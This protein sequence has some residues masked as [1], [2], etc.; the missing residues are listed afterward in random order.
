[1]QALASGGERAKRAWS[2]LNRTIASI[3]IGD[4]KR[5]KAV[6]LLQAPPQMAVVKK[7]T[8]ICHGE[9]CG[10]GCEK[11]LRPPPTK[12]QEEEEHRMVAALGP[13]S[14]SFARAGMQPS[15]NP[16]APARDAEVEMAQLRAQFPSLQEIRLQKA[17]AESKSLDEAI[18]AL[19]E[20]MLPGKVSIWPSFSSPTLPL[21][22]F[23][24]L[25]LTSLTLSLSHLSSA[26]PPA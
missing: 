22:A 3:P 12:Q 23:P 25:L 20:S 13:K 19:N 17:L 6:S 16:A 9:G 11:K 14:T 4:K 5:A 8:C 21:L 15:P 26:H 10:T 24:R 18:D 1:M 2:A 7:A